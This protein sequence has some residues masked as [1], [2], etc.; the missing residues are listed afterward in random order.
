MT[1]TEGHVTGYTV[2]LEIVE[3]RTV[4]RPGNGV[5]SPPQR[6]AR[7]RVLVDVHASTETAEA[8]RSYITSNLYQALPWKD[9]PEEATTEAPV[10]LVPATE[11]EEGEAEGSTRDFEDVF[12]DEKPEDYLNG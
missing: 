6:E 2:R 11:V 12:P 10:D 3:N 4:S 7:G 1:M 9:D 5:F 8:A